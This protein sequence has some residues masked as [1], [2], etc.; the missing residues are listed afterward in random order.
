MQYWTWPRAAG[1][2]EAERTRRRLDI[3]IAD[4]LVLCRVFELDDDFKFG[5]GEKCWP[6]RS[7]K[8]EFIYLPLERVTVPV[9]PAEVVEK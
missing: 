9:R 8:G 1:R 3:C 6:G 7:V 5:M 4:S 2:K